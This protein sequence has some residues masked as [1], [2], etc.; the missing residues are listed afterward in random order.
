MS[1]QEQVKK[2]INQHNFNTKSIVAYVLFGAIILVFILFG[3]PGSRM[4]MGSGIVAEV[5]GKIISGADLNEEYNQLE[6]FYSQMFGGNFGMQAQRQM[7]ESQAMENL[8][9]RELLS[10]EA[11]HSGVLVSDKEVREFIVDIPAFQDQG[12]FDKARYF[13]YLE[14][15]RSTAEEF[16]SKIRKDAQ[17]MRLKRMFDAVETEMSLQGKKDTEL[18]S[19][20]LNVQFAK[21]D[22]DQLAK[23]IQV[24]PDQV[25]SFIADAAN[26][27][28]IEVDYETNKKELFSNPEQVKAQH[29]LIK[30]KEG[31]AEAEKKALTRINDLKVRA[32]KEDFSEL[33]KI[34]S[35]DEGSKVKGGDLGFFGRGQMVP[36]FESAAFNAKPGEM[37]GPIKTNFGYHLIK[38]LDK[39]A[40]HVKTLD[41]VKSEIARKLLAEMQVDEKLK[42]I[43][44]ALAKKSD[45]EV[46]AQL[47]SLNVN[48]EETGEFDLQAEMIPKLF[49]GEAVKEAVWSL[50]KTGEWY[51][52]IVRDGTTRY[53]LRMKELKS[54]IVVDKAKEAKDKE[55]NMGSGGLFEA[56]LESIREKNKIHRYKSAMV[57]E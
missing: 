5:N 51:N 8:I 47:K 41:E 28:K 52:H 15:V 16:E 9:T 53:V 21:M 23:N 10:Q 38:V 34:N 43:E 2:S 19:L 44:E 40:A 20:K 36:A 27:K 13:Q 50:G 26:M 45:S 39:K 12:R 37:V 46:E 3:F 48:W 4:N 49:G 29:I 25:Q 1:L 42:K 17:R 30:A 57:E 11:T 22:R 14:N 56:W 32:T 24:T 33:A 55:M 18:A 54:I 7:L 6:R 35:E 31:D